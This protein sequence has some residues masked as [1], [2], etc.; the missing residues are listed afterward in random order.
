MLSHPDIDVN[1]QD[2][3]QQTPL[4]FA[5]YQGY[6]HLIEL[7]L[8][9]PKC[10]VDIRNKEGTPKQEAQEELNYYE[11]KKDARNEQK[12]AD[13]KEVINYME[14]VENEMLE[15]ERQEQQE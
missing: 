15:R 14:L 11:S 9:N 10:K 13:L 1:C 8:A 2:V 12:I 7:L 6:L 3:F 4:H 5:C